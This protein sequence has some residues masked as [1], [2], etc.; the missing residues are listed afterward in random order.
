MA[1]GQAIVGRMHADSLDA[2]LAGARTY[3]QIGRH[4]EAL[5]TLE[6]LVAAHPGDER[7]QLELTAARLRS[8]D[9]DG[10]LRDLAPLAEANHDSLRARRL[11]VS[12]L[13]RARMAAEALEEA[14]RL[15]RIARRNLDL[16]AD[17]LLAATCAAEL[18]EAGAVYRDLGNTGSRHLA[19]CR[20][21]TLLALARGDWRLAERHARDALLTDS[22][23]VESLYNLG[24]ALH[25]RGNRQGARAALGSASHLSQDRDES[26]VIATTRARAGYG[27]WPLGI[28]HRVR[29]TGSHLALPTWS[30]VRAS[31]QERRQQERR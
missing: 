1:H 25:L 26:V 7:V 31:R 22:S 24:L 28:L 27:P 12:A 30:G 14:R 19:W 6:R 20:A 3:S 21:A 16:A 10:A 15:H 2:Q 4:R 13:L 18:E 8:G 29:G 5:A 9:T 23:D 17:H 11:K